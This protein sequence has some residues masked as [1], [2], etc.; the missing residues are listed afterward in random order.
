MN[1]AVDSCR[2]PLAGQY[3]QSGSRSY[4]I[5]LMGSASNV[6]A[7]WRPDVRA[8]PGHLVASG[9]LVTQVLVLADVRAGDAGF[10][11]Q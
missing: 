11:Q 9:G 6:T 3:G 5:E 4:G 2:H 7:L 10:A 8:V 1:G